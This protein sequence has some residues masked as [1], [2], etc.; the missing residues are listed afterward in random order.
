VLK[1][2]PLIIFTVEAKAMPLAF[3]GVEPA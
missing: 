1:R 3:S 2:L